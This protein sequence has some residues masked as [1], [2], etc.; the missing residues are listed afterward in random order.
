MD[1]GTSYNPTP[2]LVKGDGDGTVNKR[3]LLG[4]GYW[5]NTPA[6]GN[7]KIHQQSYKGVEHYNLLNNPN[8]INYILSKLT[9]D[10]DY[11][12]PHEKQEISDMMKIRLF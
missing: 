8:A 2:I 3:S 10:R 7:H 1:F 12:R 11:P 6:Q 4:C 9:G 5:E